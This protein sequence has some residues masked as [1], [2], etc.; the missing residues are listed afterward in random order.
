[1]CTRGQRQ[2]EEAVTGVGCEGLKGVSAAAA[3]SE[4]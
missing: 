1:M 2:E 4:C 3:L